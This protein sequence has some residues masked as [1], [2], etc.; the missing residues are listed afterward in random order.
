MQRSLFP[1]PT[2][3]TYYELFTSC[4][5]IVPNVSPAG[6]NYYESV[7]IIIPCITSFLKGFRPQQ[8]LPIMNCDLTDLLQLHIHCFSF[9]P[10]QG[11]PI[12]NPMLGF[13]KDIVDT[14]GFPSPTGVTYYELCV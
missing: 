5:E 6:V 4:S 8:G 7:I 13:V 3:V 14:F 2:G 1:S 11:L 12:M 9:R 10:Q